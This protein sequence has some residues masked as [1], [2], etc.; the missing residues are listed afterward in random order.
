MKRLS[1][2]IALSLVFLLF[3]VS[4]LWA[5]I[6]GIV[7]TVS[8]GGGGSVLTSITLVNTS[9]STVNT[10]IS[11]F[12]GLQFKKTDIVAN[13]WPKFVRHDN[14]TVC[15]YSY[16][17]MRTWTDGSLKHGTFV[18]RCPGTIA[19]NSSLQI[20]VQTGGTQPTTSARTTTEITNAHISMIATGGGINLTGT[21]VA[22][23]DDAIANSTCSVWIDGDA[24]KGWICDSAY[25]KSGTAQ[26]QLSA[27]WYEFSITDGSGALG[28][29]RFLSRTWQP[30][31]DVDPKQTLEMTALGS[32]TGT[33]STTCSGGT[34]T[35]VPF[36]TGGN[37]YTSPNF[38]WDS[39]TC[40]FCFTAAGNNFY[41]GVTNG[42]GINV[43]PVTL[44]T[45]GTLPTGLAANHVYYAGI[46]SSG[47]VLLANWPD[48]E[49]AAAASG[50]GTGTHTMH[51][52]Y[53]LQN[54]NSIFGATAGTSGQTTSGGQGGYNFV[55]G[56]GSLS[57]DATLRFTKDTTY[58][59]A[60]KT[61]PPWNSNLANNT[62]VAAW[63]FN[64]DPFTIGP[65]SQ[66]VGGTGA[67]PDIGPLPGQAAQHF[68]HQDVNGETV[69]R[70]LGMASGL[71]AF[72][73]RQCAVSGG[74]CTKIAPINVGNTGTTYAGFGTNCATTC[75][76][77]AGGGDAFPLGSPPTPPSQISATWQTDFS[78]TPSMSF[79]PY[80]WSGE[81]QYLDLLYDIANED[82]LVLN[83]GN[84]YRNPLEPPGLTTQHWAVVTSFSGQTRTAA[85]ALRDTA[86]AA[87]IAPDSSFDG[88]A[89][90]AYFTDSATE[91]LK[92]VNTNIANTNSYYS[93]N[94][95]FAMR[96]PIGGGGQT[97]NDTVLFQRM[98]YMMAIEYATAL[99]EDPS[100]AGSTALTSFAN[101]IAHISATWGDW[102][103]LGYYELPVTDDA[104]ANPITADLQ[105]GNN[106]SVTSISWSSITN[107]VTV[108]A[109]RD[110]PNNNYVPADGDKWIFV[111]SGYLIGG[112]VGG[113]NVPTGASAFTAYY[114]CNTAL[115]SGVTYTFNLAT[116]PTSC[117]SHLVTITNS[118]S[119]D[120]ELTFWIAATQP[121][122]GSPY[123][124][125]GT[126]GYPSQL[127]NSALWGQAVTGN[128]S[129]MS[130][131]VTDV[132]SR[133]NAQGLYLNCGSA[134]SLAEFCMQSSY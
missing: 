22:S 63:N 45:T 89:W 37:A 55:Q 13:A 62:A 40:S 5:A 96:A 7:P 43:V 90:K 73:I 127:Y 8:S 17:M 48:G 26:G 86:F 60:T 130:H 20:D 64:W 38:T 27:R 100:S 119:S 44:T 70:V 66:D 94:G 113:G 36:T 15:S 12:I 79:Y 4:L 81:P 83:P 41:T 51:P 24:G 1:R 11:P 67:R 109:K 65:F 21:Y 68:Y 28:G 61:L 74:V 91:S 95:Y 30:Y 18:V 126:D 25:K 121:A 132:L 3:P 115:S 54:F 97:M 9:G 58:W 57:A 78:H 47:D 99:L 131:T 111:D 10:V 6:G 93:T 114:S 107:K 75:R 34:L 32:C 129:F 120:P 87:G 108:V 103:I 106:P 76:Y 42:G 84:Q 123:G 56:G 125:M 39:G 59:H 69:I 101:W 88:V 105:W 35:P 85:W 16:G 31:Y 116:Q 80:L 82:I 52:I 77:G 102:Q 72:G 19:G 23:M 133:L 134:G 49:S 33:T 92:W 118:N 14:S 104:L 71:Y 110:N 29:F 112:S 117:A 128:G 46:R 122:T 53:T 124:D 2:R 98:Y 50:A